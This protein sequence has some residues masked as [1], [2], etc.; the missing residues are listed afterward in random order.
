VLLVVAGG[1]TDPLGLGTTPL[2]DALG[3]AEDKGTAAEL[4]HAI[5]DEGVTA[6]T[7]AIQRR[8]GVI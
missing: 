2:A 5:T 3:I 1:M 8:L 7:D 4:D 6:A